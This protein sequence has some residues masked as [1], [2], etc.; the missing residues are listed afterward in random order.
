M[1]IGNKEDKY[2]DISDNDKL[3]LIIYSSILIVVLFSLTVYLL[4][5]YTTIIEQKII[6]TIA[7]ADGYSY[8]YDGTY[9]HLTR[10]TDSSNINILFRYDEENFQ[11]YMSDEKRFNNGLYVVKKDNDGNIKSQEDIVLNIDNIFNNA[12]VRQTGGLGGGYVLTQ[13]NKELS[14][15]QIAYKSN[16]SVYNTDILKQTI[17]KTPIDTS[18]IE[19]YSKRED[20]FEDSFESTFLEQKRNQFELDGY[21]GKE[22]ED[23][24]EKE[25]IRYR[26]TNNTA[27]KKNN[28]SKEVEYNTYNEIWLIPNSSGKTFYNSGSDIP[29]EDCTGAIIGCCSNKSEDIADMKWTLYKLELISLLEKTILL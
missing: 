20:S 18:F 2:Y 15:H 6:K 24:L 25:K 23:R 11:T 3:K 26:N 7:K 27:D 13:I 16:L 22:L 1:E 4:A 5:N 8:D 28:I 19:D 10:F 17:E 29:L 9:F 12:T 14:L 21:S